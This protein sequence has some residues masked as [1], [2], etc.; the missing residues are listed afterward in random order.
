[1]PDQTLVVESRAE[2]KDWEDCNNKA[3]ETIFNHIDD[4]L[5]TELG[6]IDS[7]HD[8]WTKI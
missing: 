1:M 7:A 3:I 6:V 2:I 4:Q 5:V 8:I